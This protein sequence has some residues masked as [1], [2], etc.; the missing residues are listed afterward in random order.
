[1]IA[2]FQAGNKQ[3][4]DIG[5]KSQERVPVITDVNMH[6]S[7][8]GTMK[9]LSNYPHGDPTTNGLG[10]TIKR[11]QLWRDGTYQDV[12]LIPRT[13]EDEMKCSWNN[14][15]GF[16]HQK[17]IH[18]GEMMENPNQLKELFKDLRATRAA[19]CITGEAIAPPPS[20]SSSSSSTDGV[21]GALA[22]N[23]QGPAEGLQNEP[24]NEAE[25][26]E[27][28]A[29]DDECGDGLLDMLSDSPA[30]P[31][32]GSGNAG[33]GQAAADGRRRPTSKAGG[34]AGATTGS[35]A[36]PPPLTGGGGARGRAGVGKAKTKATVSA[37]GASDEKDVQNLMGKTERLLLDF[38]GWQKAT[39][40]ANSDKNLYKKVKGII[41]DIDAKLSNA[42]ARHRDSLAIARKQLDLWVRLLKA[43]KDWAKKGEHDKFYNEYESVL[44]FM[45][46]PPRAVFDLPG[47]DFK[48]RCFFFDGWDL[49]NM[50]GLTHLCDSQV[51]VARLD[52]NSLQSEVVRGPL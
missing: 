35:S 12:V 45:D 20:Q 33:G 43:Y 16:R 10:H 19:N 21:A 14:I 36:M 17:N 15:Q 51:L 2:E 8:E 6:T 40:L 26:E 5:R 28:F 3:A 41:D 24:Q 23:L 44:K 29:D 32:A 46:E 1:M 11:N 37:A 9:L 42:C 34:K 27:D 38:T 52:R 39:L 50:F 4:K 47:C 25:M 49:S 48:Y 18:D 31:A 22:G 7:V 30:K 13:L